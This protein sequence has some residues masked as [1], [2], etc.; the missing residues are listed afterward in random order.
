M[1]GARSPGRTRAASVAAASDGRSTRHRRSPCLAP[2]R[3]GRPAGTQ[4]ESA[5]P[6]RMRVRRGSRSRG[7]RTA[8]FRPERSSD[9]RVGRPSQPGESTS[10]RTC[11]ACNRGLTRRD[12]GVV[13]PPLAPARLRSGE[14]CVVATAALPSAFA[15]V[16]RV[17]GAARGSDDRAGWC[18]HAV[19]PGSEVLLA[20]QLLWRGGAGR[21][22]GPDDHGTGERGGRVG[23]VEGERE[24]ARV[25]CEAQ[26]CGAGSSRALAVLASPLESVA[27]RPT[28]SSEG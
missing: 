16:G 8:R 2:G 11:L 17:G 3:T 27:V 26:R 28:S 1:T 13:R 24:P 20:A 5:A 10:A 21:V 25:C 23:A 7:P 22:S 18:R 6:R 14:T 15:E 4:V 9:G 19:R 12:S